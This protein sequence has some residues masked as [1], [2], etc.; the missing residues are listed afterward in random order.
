[1]RELASARAAVTRAERLPGENHRVTLRN[2]YRLVKA[3]KKAGHHD[4]GVALLEQTFPRLE[5]FLGPHDELT[6]LAGGDLAVNWAYRGRADEAVVLAERVHAAHTHVF[7]AH[8]RQTLAFRYTLA[9]AYEG[10]GR[11][12]E[13]IHLCEQELADRER[14]YGPSHH[15]AAQVRDLLTDLRRK[16]GHA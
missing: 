8:H 14:L 11:Y 7:G 12:E 6:M 16:A 10:A 13:A 5:A 2:R 3:L 1:M 9:M 15:R 4:Q